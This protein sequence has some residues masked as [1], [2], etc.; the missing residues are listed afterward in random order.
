MTIWNYLAT[1]LIAFAALALA[2]SAIARALVWSVVRYRPRTGATTARA[3]VLKPLCGA[4]ASLAV[5]LD[6]LARQTHE[7][8]DIVF[9]VA[10][11]ADEA[12]PV[13]VRFCREHEGID[14]RVEVGEDLRVDNPK[15]ALLSR[16]S[17]Y[18]QS[19]W[20]VVS[21]SNVRVTPDYVRDALARA[22]PD[23][24]LVTHLVAGQGG[25]SLA[26]HLENLQLNCFAAPGVCGARFLAG[27]TCVIG[28]SMFLRGDAL[29]AIGGFAAAGSVLAEDYVIGQSIERAGYRVV[30]APVPVIAWSEGWTLRRYVNRHLRWAVMRR[31]VSPTA[32][33]AEVLLTPSP[34]LLA[35]LG[36]GLSVPASGVD[37]LW[38]SASLFADQ[39]LDMIT[40]AR[41]TRGRVPLLAVVLNPLRQCSTLALWVLG[42]FVQ[43]VVWRGKAYRITSGSKL[44]LLAQLPRRA[45]G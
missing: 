41:M 12:L 10:D 25:R 21:D 22:E 24:G 14:A 7:N 2:V 6:A 38:V 19:Q 13:A 37:P 4:D 30:T 32:Y 8:L 39:L 34:A 28:K 1:T 36:L 15:L 17:R 16:M 3:T 44:V 11:L 40:Y 27:R 18:N 43:T 29:A 20:L 35:L 5:N 26:A 45:L 9:G 23:V 31:R 33:A 42:W